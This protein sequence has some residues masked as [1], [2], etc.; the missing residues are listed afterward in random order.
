[1]MNLHD[2]GIYDLPNPWLELY[3]FIWKSLAYA[4]CI[5]IRMDEKRT[6]PSTLHTKIGVLDMTLNCIWLFD[7][8]F[9]D[10]VNAEYPLIVI[11]LWSPLTQ[12]DFAC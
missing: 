7:F 11:T 9:G 8:S 12:I 6:P 4:D 5:L 2:A 1:M 3:L 10:L